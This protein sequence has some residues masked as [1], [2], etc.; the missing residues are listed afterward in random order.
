MSGNNRCV[1]FKVKPTLLVIYKY[2][3]L[4]IVVRFMI[5]KGVLQITVYTNEVKK[6]KYK[7]Y[8]MFFKSF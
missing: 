7:Y 4:L 6:N 5:D 1:L 3:V 8:I 2:F